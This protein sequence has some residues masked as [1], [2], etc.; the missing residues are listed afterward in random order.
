MLKKF[1]ILILLPLSVSF[2]KTPRVKRSFYS[3]PFSNGFGA[4]VYQARKKGARLLYFYDH[5]YKQYDKRH[6]TK[7]YLR[8]GAYWGI[9]DKWLS[10]IKLQKAGYEKGTGIVTAEKKYDNLVFHESYFMPF[11]ADANVIVA[12]LEISNTGDAIDVTPWFYLD[13]GMGGGGS[14]RNEEVKKSGKAF[15]E[16]KKKKNGSMS[17]VTLIP[18]LE[19]ADYKPYRDFDEAIRKHPLKVTGRIVPKGQTLTGLFQLKKTKL[20]PGES[21][22][23]VVLM[24][25]GKSENEVRM[26]DIVKK[27]SKQS[28]SVLLK[29]ARAEWSQWQAKSLIPKGLNGDALLLYR[30]S[31]SMLRMGQVRE[32]GPPHGQIL[33]SMPPGQWN[34]T[35]VRDGVYS[36]LALIKSGHFT[37][38]K[39]ALK[40]MLNAPD[41]RF[42]SPKYVGMPYK[43]SVCRYYGDG[44]EESDRNSDG[45][46]IEWDNF[47]LFLQAFSTYAAKSGDEDFVKKYYK[48]V[49]KKVADVLI[50]LMSK[51]GYLIPDSSIWERH[52]KPQHS[53]DG[54][55]SFS[56][57]TINAI[58]GLRA[59]AKITSSVKHAKKYKAA[60][61]KMQK[62]LLKYMVVQN[63]VVA[64]VED[65][66]KG[67]KGAIDA[68][69][70][71]AIN[72]GMVD[73][74]IAKKT[75]AVFENTLKCPKSPGFFRNDDGTWY[76]NQ[77]WVFVDMRIARAFRKLGMKKKAD[78]L[79]NWIIANARANFWLIP[80]LIEGNSLRW[81]GAIPMM[82]FGPGAFILNMW[83]EGKQ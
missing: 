46:N 11:S 55:K 31:L 44:E 51:E 52:W 63:V 1:F 26:T 45:P 49:E 59:F 27:I 62:A 65:G 54:R 72:F 22:R 56:Y 81:T 12:V 39:A 33:A 13:T 78:K 64:S 40:F 7:S 17:F 20:T 60:A 74:K 76:D 82:G 73:K 66:R 58:E 43:I 15:V 57:S 42:Y 34:I 4:G 77:E 8:K 70:V 67:L 25:L 2:A 23:Y 80:E 35:W 53:P 16:F 18:E 6:V 29:N 61:N 79:E 28:P 83:Q 24:S 14:S 9:N 71:E 10:K 37:E 41:G 32:P 47:G 19:K 21:K 30:Q 69:S 75:L 36:I 48:T 5:L 38:A 50:Q 3:L 68:S